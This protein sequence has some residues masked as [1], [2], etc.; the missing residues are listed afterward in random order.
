MYVRTWCEEAGQQHRFFSGTRFIPDRRG[1]A[2][3]IPVIDQGV[4]T[5][6]TAPTLNVNA[7]SNF[8]LVA[9]TRSIPANPTS[10]PSV[11]RLR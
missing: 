7:T 1:S 5:A 2:I 6:P 4:T 10:N 3:G 9:D 8:M 11:F